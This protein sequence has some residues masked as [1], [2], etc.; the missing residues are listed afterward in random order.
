MSVVCLRNVVNHTLMAESIGERIKRERLKLELTQRELAEAVDVGVPHISKIEADRESPSDDLLRRLA[1]VFKVDEEEL[2]L[3]ARRVPE[4]VV[5]DLA[6]D[7]AAGLAFLREFP[8][9]Q[10][11]K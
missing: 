4:S 1:K 7:P 9:S 11:R 6:E 2:L 8:S 5:E 10:G 3:A